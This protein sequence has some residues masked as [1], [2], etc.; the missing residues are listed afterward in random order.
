MLGDQKRILCAPAKIG[1][2]Q[3][4]SRLCSLRPDFGRNADWL[5]EQCHRIWSKSTEVESVSSSLGWWQWKTFV[6]DLPS[7]ERRNLLSF[8]IVSRSCGRKISLNMCHG[9]SENWNSCT[10]FLRFCSIYGTNL[11]ELRSWKPQQVVDREENAFFIAVQG[12]FVGIII[13]ASAASLKVT[14]LSFYFRVSPRWL[15]VVC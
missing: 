13:K 5:L 15:F 4:L 9:N 14:D 10:Y 11:S 1:L 8:F 2:I 3:T 6:N 12:I 7:V